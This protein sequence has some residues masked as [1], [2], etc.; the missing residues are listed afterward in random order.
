MLW[1]ASRDPAESNTE[2]FITINQQEFNENV[3]VN[4]GLDA[5]RVDWRREKKWVYKIIEELLEK[6]VTDALGK[7]QSSLIDQQ[8]P[9]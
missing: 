1:T 8:N 3:T 6:N 4:P 2:N 9:S 5:P 7:S